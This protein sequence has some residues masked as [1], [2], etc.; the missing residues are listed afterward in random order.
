MT[1]IIISAAVAI[2][3]ALILMA[4]WFIECFRVA[5][6]RDWDDEEDDAD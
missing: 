4:K 1:V 5:L 2:S 6:T 3:C